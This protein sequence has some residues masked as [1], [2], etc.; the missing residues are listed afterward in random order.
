MKAL[1]LALAIWLFIGFPMTF[2]GSYFGFKREAFEYPVRTNLIPRQIPAQTM[3]NKLLSR[4]VLG[5]LIVFLS[6]FIQL[7]FV[8]DDLLEHGRPTTGLYAILVIASLLSAFVC[9]MVLVP[10]AH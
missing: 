10:S 5:G 3:S 8:N 9:A 4:V 6:F 2:A 7:F 1:F